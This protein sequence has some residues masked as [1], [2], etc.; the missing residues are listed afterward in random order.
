MPR[1]S[2]VTV[3]RNAERAIAASGLSLRHQAWRDYEWLVIDGASTD[4]TLAVAAG[5]CVE[6]TRVTSEPDAGIYDAMNKAVS[7]ARGEW[8]YFLNAGDALADDA[9]LV[10]VAAQLDAHPAVE[11]LWGDMIYFGAAGEWLRRYRHVRRSTLV[12]DDLNH[13]AVFARRVLFERSGR[14]NLAFRTS[15]DY[16]W[17]LRVFRAGAVTRYVPRV[18]ARFEVGGAHR[19]DPAALDAE[20][21]TL[22]LQYIRPGALWLGEQLSRV[23]RRWRIAMG[24]GG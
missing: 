14:F 8:I 19:A 7:L 18:I 3:C 16:D 6:P 20:R 22:R 17:L 23:R 4:R 5:L 15:A 1:F 24:H 9:V 11:L 12:F 2:I 21:R 10:D 13:Q